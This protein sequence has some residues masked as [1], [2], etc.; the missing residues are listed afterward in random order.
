MLPRINRAVIGAVVTCVA[1]APALTRADEGAIA[2]LDEAT[3]LQRVRRSPRVRVHDARRRAADAAVGA[4]TV[5]PNPTI[6]YER[7]AVPGPGAADDFLRLG[8]AI[9]L[10]GRR[11]LARSAAQAGADAERA[12]TARDALALEIEARLAYLEAAHARGLATQLE[13]ARARLASIA[14]ALRSRAKQGDA[15][16]YDAERAALELETLDDE[17]ADARRRLEGARLR[18]GALVGEPRAAY[19]ASDAITLPAQPRAGSELR[20]ADVDAARA[21]ARQA[22]REAEAAGRTWVPRLEL[23]AGVMRSTSA[24]GDGVGYILGV[25]GSLPLL[26]RGG[27]QEARGRAEARRWRGE[28]DALAIEAEGEALQARRELIARIE[29]AAAYAA[30]PARRAAEL[31]RRAMVAYREGD[32]PILELLDVHRA[33][34]HAAAR[35]LELVYEARRAELALARA[36]G[37]QP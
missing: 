25:G 13:G 14:E 7:E 30:G 1:A 37:G 3:F 16:D 2:A 24:S 33:A 17:R 21:R 27:A 23:V 19:D 31:E 34:R 36:L 10:S 22:E 32:R 29:Q 20:R 9:D 11:G 4:A 15:S 35:E 18:L 12:S 6:S 28:A 5:L 26:D 8:W